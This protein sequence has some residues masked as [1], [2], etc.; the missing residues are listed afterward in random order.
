LGL[1]EA[2]MVVLFG[3]LGVAPDV[4]LALS[5]AF[6]LALIV[7][8]LPGCVLWLLDRSSAQPGTQS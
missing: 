4:A 5:I 7:A 8:A 6:G 1:R 3:Y 2:A